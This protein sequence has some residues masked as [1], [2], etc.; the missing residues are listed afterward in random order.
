MSRETIWRLL[1]R[2]WL[3]LVFVCAVAVFAVDM[4]LGGLDEPGWSAVM[5]LTSGTGA[6]LGT[7][8]PRR[9]SDAD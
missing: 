1:G 3:G 6:W 2:T 8:M 5:A 4:V 7:R 9:P